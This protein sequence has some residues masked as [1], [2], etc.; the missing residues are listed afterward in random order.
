MDETFDETFDEKLYTEENETVI[1]HLEFMDH[2]DLFLYQCELYFVGDVYMIYYCPK[3]DNDFM[4]SESEYID[5]P[6]ITLY[7]D[8]ENKKLQQAFNNLENKEDIISDWMEMGCNSLKLSQ[9]KL[10]AKLLGLSSFI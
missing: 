6:P 9:Q 5:M 7:L 1:N 4:Y 2:D 8:F 10:Y 3:C